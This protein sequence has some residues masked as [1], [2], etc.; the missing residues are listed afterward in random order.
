MGGRNLIYSLQFVLLTV[1]AAVQH[2]NNDLHPALHSLQDHL[3]DLQIL[4]QDKSSLPSGGSDLNG[5]AAG[6][7]KEDAAGDLNAD[8][9]GDLNEDAAGDLNEDSAGDLQTGISDHIQAEIDLL[10]RIGD[11]REQSHELADPGSKSGPNELQNEA[12][13]PLLEEARSNEETFMGRMVDTL[14]SMRQHFFTW[15]S[16]SW[17]MYFFFLNFMLHRWGLKGLSHEN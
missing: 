10:E 16:I 7:L 12:Q 1:T 15:F 17:L 3:N 11:F 6:D 9:A 2:K 13:W 14:K 5:D 4:L 8:A